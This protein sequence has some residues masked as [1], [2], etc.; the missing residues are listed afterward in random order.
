MSG[1]NLDIVDELDPSGQYLDISGNEHP[2]NQGTS[3]VEFQS[4]PSNILNQSL[5]EDIPESSKKQLPQCLTRCILK[6]TYEPELSSKVRYLMNHYVST[7]QLSKINQSF[8]N[9]LSIVSI[10]NSVQEA[11]T[12]PRWKAAINEEMA[13]LQKNQTWELVDLPTEKKTVGCR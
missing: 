6:P 13:S 1:Q 11:L 3:E 10:P 8:V 2:E 4:L 7:H 9:Q 12:D 5:V